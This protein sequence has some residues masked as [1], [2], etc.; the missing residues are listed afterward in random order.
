MNAVLDFL[1]R[2]SSRK[3]I[4]AATL[5][6]AGLWAM[7]QDVDPAVVQGQVESYAKYVPQ[8]VGALMAV[9]GA[10][11]FIKAEGAID[12]AREAKK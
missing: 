7:F 4:A 3:F 9:L 12:A 11:G 5:V 2:I 6:V 1:K 8:V 10:L